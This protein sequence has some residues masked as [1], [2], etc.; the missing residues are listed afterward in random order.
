MNI[1]IFKASIEHSKKIWE[2]RNDP[3]SLQMSFNNK[4]VSWYEHQ[5]WYK[6]K[7]NKKDSVIY[8]SQKHDVLIG[9][10]RF[11]NCENK[12]KIYEISINLAPEIRGKGLGEIILNRSKKIFLKEKKQC[13]I[14][15]ANIKKENKVSIHLF[16]KCGFEI[17]SHDDIK[18]TLLFHIN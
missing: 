6:E 18:S 10:V 3:V 4:K 13:R 15:K 7:L 1:K 9:V 11:D 14:I 17:T 8:I 2:W 5:K 12:N 16:L